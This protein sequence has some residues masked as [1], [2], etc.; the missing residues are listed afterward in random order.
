MKEDYYDELK[1]LLFFI[2]LNMVVYIMLSRRIGARQEEDQPAQPAQPQG[3][4]QAPPPAAPAAPRRRRRSQDPWV[5]PWILQREDRG[6]YR[7]LLD[8]L[9]T[10]DIPGYRNFVRMPPAVF[11]R[12]QERIA[13]RL[14]KEETNWRKPLQV[15]LKLAAT[16]RH[17]STGESYTSL[18]YQWR[19][20]RTTMVKFVPEVCRA[21]LA[22]FQ[23]EYLCCPT[24]EDD[25]KRIAHRFETRWNVPH[26]IGALDGKHIAM[27]KPKRSGSEYYNYK[28]F[29]S[30]VL[31][32]LVD[33]DYK[34]LWVDVGS[35]GSCS[36]AQIFN[37]SDL[38][39]R[40]EGNNL[41]LPPPRPIGPG[42]QNI[43]YF[44]LG[45]DAFAL[46]TWLVKPYSRRHLTREERIANYRISRGRRVVENAFGILVSRFRVLLSTMEQRPEV[47]RDI[48]LTCVVLH[49]MLRQE[50]Q[51]GADRPPM[52]A[53]DLLGAGQAENGGNN[54]G[55]N[56]SRLAKRQRDLLKDYFNN[57][58][59]IDGQ[60]D[61]I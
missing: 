47:V 23:E 46:Q 35:S 57:L 18:H 14:R 26:A 49:N 6:C 44:I 9:I 58:G 55:R 61:R 30:M 15:G 24:E 29:F 56:P 4:D 5:M 59:A 52:P 41:G 1:V 17:L 28:H 36:D 8:E 7:T 3:Q 45:D 21:I 16:L 20:G 34:F 2:Q 37:R 32:A 27:K 11:D 40:I 43:H 33:A 48:V 22:E 39:E 13:H 31:L 50:V 54:R 38:R 53:D 19:V 10:T 60:A 42:G 25:W 12:I 51:A